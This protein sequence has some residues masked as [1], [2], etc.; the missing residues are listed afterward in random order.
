MKLRWKPRL[1]VQS[2]LVSTMYRS[3]RYNTAHRQSVYDTS[4][5]LALVQSQRAFLT[6]AWLVL[7]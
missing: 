5:V 3:Q 2:R 4:C 6:V 7:R 1:L